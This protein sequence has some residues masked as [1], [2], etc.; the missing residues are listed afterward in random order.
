MPIGKRITPVVSASLL[1]GG[2]A[3]ASVAAFGGIH[4]GSVKAL[5]TGAAPRQA[6]SGY[7]PWPV[8]SLSD[9]VENG[10]YARFLNVG[11]GKVIVQTLSEIGGYTAP[12]DA[13]GAFPLRPLP[14]E[15][16]PSF[17][18]ASHGS[19]ERSG[20]LPPIVSRNFGERDEPSGTSWM[21]VHDGGGATTTSERHGVGELTGGCPPP[22]S[23]PI[24]GA[25][26]LFASG[27]AVFAGLGRNRLFG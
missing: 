12:S 25:I 17:K 20:E 24:P 8:V 1:L 21:P 2:V 27:L 18:D 11:H 4:F 23:V 16:A 7:T 15:E 5:N 6:L 3:L 13:S 14:L 22:K 9:L 19:N 10:A 26:V